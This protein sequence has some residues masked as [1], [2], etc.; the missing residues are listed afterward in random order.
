[1]SRTPIALTSTLIVLLPALAPAQS[2]ATTP[3]SPQ[4]IALACAPPP[5]LADGTR[6][7]PRIAGA[8]DTVARGVF[9]DRDLLI[10]AG[11]TSTGITLGERYFVRR[12]VAAPNYSNRLGL[13][14]PIQTAGWVRVVA[15][16]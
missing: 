9:D 4:Q 1:M 10:I 14:H 5:E 13:R 15:T 6:H 12:P 3:M 11:G 2:A 16:N 7:A 8:Q